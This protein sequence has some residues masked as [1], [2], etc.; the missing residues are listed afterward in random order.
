M[1]RSMGIIAAGAWGLA[2]GLAAGLVSMSAAIVAAGFKWPWRDNEHGIWPWLFVTGVGL[3]LGALVAAAAHGQ[4]TGGWPAFIMGVSAPSIIRGAI[5]KIEAVPS[6][7]TAG[8][9]AEAVAS[10]IAGDHAV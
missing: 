8:H 3:V 1:F 7:E 4:M 5:S 9:E 2:G 6:K 10:D